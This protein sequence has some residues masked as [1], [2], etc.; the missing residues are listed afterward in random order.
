MTQEELRAKIIEQRKYYIE[1]RIEIITAQFNNLTVF[2]SEYD[3]PD[4]PMDL[5]KETYENVIVKNLVRC[6]AIPKDKLEIG[7]TYIGACRNSNEATWTGVEF[8]YKRYKFGSYYTDTIN[9][10]ED[11]DGYDLFVPIK[12]KI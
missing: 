3:V 8:E 2:N 11:D 7:K 6:G 4:I 9:H 10:F 5:D 1:H 12:I